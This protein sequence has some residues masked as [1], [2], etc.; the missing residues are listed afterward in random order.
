MRLPFDYLS[1]A[2]LAIYYPVFG[3]ELFQEIIDHLGEG[4]LEG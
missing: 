3:F 2:Y 4:H 1:I